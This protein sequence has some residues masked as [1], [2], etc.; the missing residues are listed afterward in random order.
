MEMVSCFWF[1]GIFVGSAVSGTMTFTPFWSMGVTTMKMIR[2]T[3]QTSTSGVTL[4]SLR[5]WL[6]VSI[7]L[8][9][10][11]S[12]AVPRLLHEE[13][14][15]LGRGVRHLDVQPVQLVGEVVEHPGRRD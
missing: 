2:S 12:I 11:G 14:D 7:F 9:C 3:R 5:M 6:E 15:Q 4:M 10:R 8:T 1:S 13:I